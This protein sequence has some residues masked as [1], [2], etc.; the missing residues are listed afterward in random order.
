MTLFADVIGELASLKGL[1]FIMALMILLAIVGRKRTS[2]P[3]PLRVAVTSN[4][5]L[6]LVRL[7]P[8]YTIHHN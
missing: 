5:S 8:Q 3:S 4:A 6:Y 7:M 1:K 2:P